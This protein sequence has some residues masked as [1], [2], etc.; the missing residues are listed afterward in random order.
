MGVLA[1][2]VAEEIHRDPLTHLAEHPADSRLEEAHEYLA[3]LVVL[4]RLHV[5]NNL[6]SVRLICHKKLF[7]GYKDSAFSEYAVKE[8]RL[9]VKYH[10]HGISIPANLCT[11]AAEK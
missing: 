4:Q 8:V 6:L 3:L 2:K 5:F 10:T 11:F 9:F 1:E 7:S